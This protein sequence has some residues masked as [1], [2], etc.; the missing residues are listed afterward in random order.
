MREFDEM[1]TIL[2]LARKSGFNEVEA[3]IGEFEFKAKLDRIA[4]SGTEIP[5][6]EADAPPAPR[7]ADVTAPCV[8]YFRTL[9]DGVRVGATV[10]AGQIIGQIEALGLGNDVECTVEGEVVEVMAS[11]DQPLQYGQPIIRV[12]VAP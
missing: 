10:S 6:L 2:D 7:T 4:P 12:K 11:K 1:R 3:S 9:S 8:G 5:V